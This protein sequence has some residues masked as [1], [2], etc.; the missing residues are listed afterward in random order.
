M[1]EQLKELGISYDWKRVTLAVLIIIN[2]PNGCFYKCISMDWLIRKVNVNWCP[3]CATVLA[4]EQVVNGHCERCK[5]L[6]GK[7]DLEQWFSK[8]PSTLKDTG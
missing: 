6:V 5:S 8:L 4:N 7:K 1:R 3:S 2:G